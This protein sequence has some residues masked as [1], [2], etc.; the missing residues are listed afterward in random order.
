[1]TTRLIE[2]G[3]EQAIEVEFYGETRESDESFTHAFGTH[4]RIETECTH[5]WWNEKKY[6]PYENMMIKAYADKHE[7][8]L[9]Q[10]IEENF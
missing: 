3:I 2:I 6:T 1:M 7:G 4:K 5:V 9:K 10:E 8:D